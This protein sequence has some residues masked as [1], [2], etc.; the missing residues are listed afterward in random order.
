[1]FHVKNN[2][3]A[4]R[5]VFNTNQTTGVCH[6]NKSVILCVSPI[7]FILL[8]QP[9]ATNTARCCRNVVRALWGKA[10]L[11]DAFS[12]LAFAY[13]DP[14]WSFAHNATFVRILEG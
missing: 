12:F 3:V 11:F 10:K 5:S 13:M 2:A 8:S 4:S 9:W 14:I 6:G 1:V 7:F